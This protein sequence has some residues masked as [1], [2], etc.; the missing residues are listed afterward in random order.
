MI[1]YLN[2]EEKKRAIPL[3]NEAF[4]EDAEPFLDYYFTEKTKDN[5]ILVC[6][7]EGEIVSML[8]R[9]PYSIFMRGDV[10]TCDYI[11]AVATK[12]SE[13]HKGHMRSLLLNMLR[14]MQEERMPFTFLMPARESLYTPYDFRFIFDQPRWVLRYNKDIKKVPCPGGALY[15]E[16]AEWQ[17]AWL[18]RQ[19]DVFAVRDAA[20]LERMEKE[21]KS[22]N[23]SCS[24]IY[25][26]DWFIGME[27]EWGSAEKNLRYLY[28]GERYRT[29]AGSRPAIMARIVCMPEFIK[30][31]RLSED[32]P[33]QEITIEIGVTDLFVPQNQGAWLWKLT[34]TG[35][36]MVQE[37][38]FIAKGKVAVFTISELTQW[39]FG[40][41]LPKQVSE[42]PYGSCIEP[43]RGIFLD[44]VV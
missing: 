11:V 14:D 26:D 43:L 19:Y 44:E 40:Y 39:L 38:R 41:A 5:R 34:K 17:N 20:Y 4:P 33:E 8:H 32:C 16:L 29:S 42:L 31:I 21:L 10:K 30:N 23:G 7:K 35:S 3:W 37:S 36:E 24:L 28:T 12:V 2:Q 27:S 1:R 15:E 22:E 25:E 6:E 9:N 13:R 18:K